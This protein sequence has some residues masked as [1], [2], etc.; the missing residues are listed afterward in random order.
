MAM[1]VA[2][3]AANVGAQRQQAK[4]Q[5]AAQNQASLSEM[6]RFSFHSEQTEDDNRTRKR[7]RLLSERKRGAK[8]LKGLRRQSPPLKKLECLEPLL[9]W[10]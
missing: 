2:S 9:G 10:L 5:E 8:K 7:Q 4:A 1:S 6:E 3:Q